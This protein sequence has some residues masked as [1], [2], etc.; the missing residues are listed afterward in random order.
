MEKKLVSII[1]RSKNE[2]K[3]IRLV[4]K[5]IRNQTIKNIEIILVDNKSSDNTLKIAKSFGVKK[6]LTINKFLP[7]AALNKGCNEALGK[8][9]VFLSAHCVPENANW[10]KELIS[11]IDEKKRIIA[12]YGKQIPL[13]YSSANDVR[14]LLITFGSEDRIQSEDPFFHNANS[15]ILK[16][17]WKKY[18]FNS[19]VTNIEDRLWAK[20]ILKLNYKIFYNSK[21]SVYH[22]HGIHHA[23]NTSRSQSTLK[24]L[25]NT[26]KYFVK[27]PFF[28]DLQKREIH[29][30]IFVN[31]IKENFKKYLKKMKMISK[32]TYIS[33][34]HV[35]TSKKKTNLKKIKFYPSRNIHD[36]SLNKKFQYAYKVISSK[37][38]TIPE[39][40]LYI[41]LSYKYL[42]NSSINKNLKLFL[43]EG[44]DT[45][46]PVIKDYSINWVFNESEN[47]YKPI[48]KNFSIRDYK[49]PILKSLF[50]LGTVTNF[51][52]LKSGDLISGRYN[53]YIVDEQKNVL[54]DLVK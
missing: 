11:K 39:L 29:V 32:N 4:L 30:L 31:E 53:F 41:N 14:D 22:H 50:G 3:W 42:S 46:I 2:E 45:L 15:C 12:C 44:F 20:R 16:K 40:I 25:A 49:K 34:L 35:F 27:K 17:F 18:K 10:L 13:R 26:D 9:L 19:H 48:S 24:V 47:I 5:S 52:N 51:N 1:I 23:L 38:R 54:R 28:F 7:G 6:I 36:M 33:Q 43:K 8:Y 37:N 21:A